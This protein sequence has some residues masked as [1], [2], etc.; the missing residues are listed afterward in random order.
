MADQGKEYSFD[1]NEFTMR[2][3]ESCFDEFDVNE[4]LE[5]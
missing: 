5:V 4:S 3:N 1:V 2:T